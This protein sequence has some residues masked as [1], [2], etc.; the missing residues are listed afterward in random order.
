MI[1]SVLGIYFLG[2]VIGILIAKKAYK[3]IPYRDDRT[4]SILLIL[5]IF[6]P[7]SVPGIIAAVVGHIL[8]TWISGG[9]AND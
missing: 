7:I 3:Y 5:A 4:P 2:V 1:N 8:C 6:W 9:Q